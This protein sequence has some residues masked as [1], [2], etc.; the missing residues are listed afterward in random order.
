MDDHKRKQGDD[1]NESN[2]VKRSAV[3]NNSKQA[4]NSCRDLAEGGKSFVDPVVGCTGKT[5]FWK[6]SFLYT[7]SI[8]CSSV[9]VFILFHFVLDIYIVY[10]AIIYR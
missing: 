10:S 6:H 1:E 3:D 5:L 9:P 4:C 2:A 7:N 8:S